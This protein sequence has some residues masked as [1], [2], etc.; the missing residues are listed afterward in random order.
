[1]DEEIKS[2]FPLYKDDG[3]ISVDL[4]HNYVQNVDVLKDAIAARKL[5][6]VKNYCLC[7]N[8]NPEDD[9][10]VSM[11][12]RYGLSIPQ[13]LCSKCGLIRSGLVFDDESN[14]IFYR[15]YYRT[16]YNYKVNVTT[17]ELFNAHMVT[18]KRL[19]KIVTDHLNMSGIQEVAEVGCSCGYNLY[20][21]YLEGVDVVGFDFNKEYLEY[22]RSKGL[23]LKYGDFY[24]QTVD[25]SFD[26]IILNHVYEHLLDPLGE[27]KR[28]IPKVKLSK[29][30]YIEVPGIYSIGKSYGSPLRY[31]QN[32]HVFNF[33]EQYLRVLFVKFGLNIIYSNER[34]TFLCQKTSNE[35]PDVKEVFDES[36]SEYVEKNAQ[37]LI[38]CDKKWYWKKYLRRAKGVI[39]D[40]LC[41]LRYR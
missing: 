7:N 29:Y 36:L 20:P 17:D 9:I 37:Y 28:L 27:L 30:I 19:H 24:D 33:Y 1:M 26:L 5:K 31:F 8:E 22:G 40:I 6:L 38:E 12:D 18:A 41:T 16:I 32:A 3:L 11:K 34:C 39:G 13:V 2:Q 10:V 14:T 35:I 15:D 25:N 4:P 21:F 23:N